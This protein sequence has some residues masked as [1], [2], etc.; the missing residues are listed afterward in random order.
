MRSFEVCH[1]KFNGFSPRCVAT[2]AAATE[3]NMFIY[4]MKYLNI[5]LSPPAVGFVLDFDKLFVRL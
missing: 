3:E 1:K 2:V 5:P 4:N